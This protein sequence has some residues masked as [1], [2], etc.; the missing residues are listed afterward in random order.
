MQT[1]AEG[2][3]VLR[4]REHAVMDIVTERLG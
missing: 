3:S 2:V 4:H 1:K